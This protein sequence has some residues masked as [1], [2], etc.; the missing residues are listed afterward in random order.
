[1]HAAGLLLSFVFV[2]LK[3]MRRGGMAFWLSCGSVLVYCLEGRFW[4]T[5]WDVN[6]MGMLHA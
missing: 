4:K 2:R 5:V 3:E 6:F 1:M